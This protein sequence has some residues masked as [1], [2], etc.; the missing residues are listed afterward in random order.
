M[1]EA[2]RLEETQAKTTPTKD[3]HASQKEVSR[4]RRSRGAGW[5]VEGG[6]GGRVKVKVE[7]VPV[8]SCAPGRGG[9]EGG[10]EGV[11]AVGGGGW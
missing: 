9:R 5:K 6:A 8:G 2:S 4:R 10:C 3:K 7:V 11:V 1:I